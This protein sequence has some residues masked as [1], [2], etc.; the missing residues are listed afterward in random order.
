MACNALLQP[1]WYERENRD[2]FLEW[3]LNQ[4]HKVFNYSKEMEEYCIS[5]VQILHQCFMAFHELLSD[6]AELD[7]FDYNAITAANTASIVY[8]AK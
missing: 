5:D 4:A 2:S 1:R 3:L 6:I 8:R 7:V